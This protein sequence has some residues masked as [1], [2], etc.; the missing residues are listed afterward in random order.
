ML[1]DHLCIVMRRSSEYRRLE[2]PRRHK[3]LWWQTARESPQP[4][5]TNDHNSN[6]SMSRIRSNA[7]YSSLPSS[8]NYQKV[9]KKS[10]PLL[11]VFSFLDRL[12]SYTILILIPLPNNY[13]SHS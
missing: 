5:A 7:F 11:T 3:A 4:T 2:H 10:V 6:H 9:A 13:A 1:P 12:N 8:T